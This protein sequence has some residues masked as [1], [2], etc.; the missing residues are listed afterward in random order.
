MTPMR[1]DRS[2]QPSPLGAAPGRADG[3]ILVLFAIAMVAMLIALAL[4]FD[5]AQAL[6]LRRQLQNASDAGALAGANLF[7]TTNDGCSSTN[8]T[9]ARATVVTAVKASIVTNLG[10]STTKADSNVTVTCPSG[11]LN[12]GVSVAVKDTSA[13]FFGMFAGAT[14][15]AVGASSVAYNGPVGQG[16]FSV[17]QLDP[18]PPQTTGWPN[19]FNGCPSVT[20]AGSAQLAFGGSVQ[21]DSACTAVNGGAFG[22]NGNASV[23]CFGVLDF[24]T[25]VCTPSGG[26]LRMVGTWTQGP[27]VVTPAP[28]INQ[29]YVGDPLASLASPSTSGWL[30]CPGSDSRCPS[31]G[32]NGTT[33]GNGQNGTCFVLSPGVYNGGIVVKSQGAVFMRPGIYLMNGGGVTLEAQASLYSISTAT[34]GGNC[35]LASLNPEGGTPAGTTWSSTLCPV[36]TSNTPGS[37][38][39]LACGVLIVNQCSA[40]TVSAANCPLT[41]Q[42]NA[43]APFGAISLGGGS[44]FRLRAFCTEVPAGNTAAKCTDTNFAPSE[45]QSSNANL[46]QYRNIVVWQVAQPAPSS[47]YNQPIIS[48]RGGGSAYEAGTVYAP[49]GQV[50]LGGNC[51]GNGGVALDLTLQFI[52][53]DLGITGSCAYNFLYNV[54]A[55]ATFPAYGLVK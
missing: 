38:G 5:G 43:P 8:N 18:G 24:T 6:V 51:A 50:S 16:K 30:V 17:M 3:Q 21:V 37:S 19:G 47:T 12:Y 35:S 48:L 7:L 45:Q 53:W 46:T 23:I 40:T 29:P 25:N 39:P 36:A 27:N 41:G 15:I 31:N 2:P 9:T 42:G 33:I 1:P 26:T 4:V 34:S 13:T 49:S 11:Y 32:G 22:V 20:F 44:G 52:S 54:N 14:N 28:L 55:F 10:W